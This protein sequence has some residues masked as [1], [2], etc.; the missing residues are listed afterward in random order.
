MSPLQV[1]L[2]KKAVTPLREIRE[3]GVVTSPFPSLLD[4][5]II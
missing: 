3:I 5:L 2:S 1:E 4:I